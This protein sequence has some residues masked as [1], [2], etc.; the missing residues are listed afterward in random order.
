LVSNLTPFIPLSFQGEGEIILERG[1][2]PLL[3]ALEN[4]GI[5]ERERKLGGLIRNV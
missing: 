4:G 1:A 5:M 2:K 3:N